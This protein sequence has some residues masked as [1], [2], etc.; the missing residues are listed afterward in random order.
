[1]V[2]WLRICLPMQATYFQSLVW[3]DPTCCRATKSV[4]QD[5][6][7]RD[8]EFLPYRKIAAMKS[9]HTALEGSPCLPQLEK[10]PIQQWRPS[11]AKN[12]HINTKFLKRCYFII[13]FQEKG[14]WF[15]Y[16][17]FDITSQKF[18]Y[19]QNS[20]LPWGRFFFNTFWT[21]YTSLDKIRECITY[22][23]DVSMIQV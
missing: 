1:M 3:E 12:K 2:Q 10:A 14:H 23:W 19:T 8:L 5:S 20:E 13:T 18:I 16:I 4:R 11:V 21:L 6:W 22:Y 9:L 7:A 17:F 15:F